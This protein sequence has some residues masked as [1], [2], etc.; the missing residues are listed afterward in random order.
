MGTMT[1]P[2]G[3]LL[4]LDDTLYGNYAACN[5]AGIQ[6]ACFFLSTALDT[7]LDS[8][9][10]AFDESR[11]EVHE[12]LGETASSHSRYLY[13]KGCIERITGR[14]R[15]TLCHKAEELF[16]QQF[17][18]TMM[19]RDGLSSFLSEAKERSCRIAVVSDLTTH[20]QTMKLDRLS[21]ET[22][23]DL[24]VTSEET[25]SDKPHP[26]VFQLAL[27]RL[28]LRPKETV[29]V[30][31]SYEKDIRGAEALDIRGV[32]MAEERSTSRDCARAQDFHE[33]SDMLF[34]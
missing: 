21:I 18:N 12:R 28:S 6:A 33:L 13:L 16:W 24:M 26:A 2:Q 19:P 9:R 5:K 8:V 14:S 22:Y 20:T 34:S 4:D 11:E 29:M 31:D 10:R 27:Q 3:I 30:G 23:V 7:S 32:L 1:S 17:L 15:M 25:G